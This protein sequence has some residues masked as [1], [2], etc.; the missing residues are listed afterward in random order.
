MS[1]IVAHPGTQHS[2]QAALG[3][4]EAEFLS[5]YVTGYYYKDSSLFTRSISFL[6]QR[7][8]KELEREIRRRYLPGLDQALVNT[9]PFK[10]LLYIACARSKYLQKRAEHVLRWRNEAFDRRIAELVRS[11]RPEAVVLFDSCARK[12][13]EMCA[14]TGTIRVLDQSIGFIKEGM[15]IFADEI[16]SNPEFADTLPADVPGWLVDRCTD[17]IFL[18]DKILAG[19]EYVRETLVKNGIP[20]QKVFILPYG[21]DIERFK[22]VNRPDDGTFR[23]LFVGGIGQRKGIKY[24]LE[25]VKHLDLPDAELVLAGGIIGS[26]KGLE[27]YKEYFRHVR[28]TP[29]H[30]IHKIFQ[31]ADVFVYPSLHEGSAI[32]T[33]EAL[34]SGLPVI[35]TPNSGSVVRNGEDGFI[36]PPRSAE[37]L[38]EKIL[39]L[40][41]DKELR[42]SMGRS[43]R[44]RAKDF[45]WKHYRLRLAQLMQDF[46]LDRAVIQSRR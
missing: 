20:T 4:Q 21:V 15:K 44:E 18:A 7:Y 29:H 35:T 26:G 39:L 38:M 11:E 27:M 14:Q 43:A 42:Q 10:E 33:Y 5:K 8:K 16:E 9:V 40:Y 17:E 28:N 31:T 19:S 34:A 37:V 12:A 23:I 25:A 3:L 45:T 24:L 6:P 22:P 1:V 13:F 30:E 2:Y 32:A 41:S 46:V 36:V